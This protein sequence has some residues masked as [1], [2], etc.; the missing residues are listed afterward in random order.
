MRDQA[1][2]TFAV[3]PLF[4]VAPRTSTPLPKALDDDTGAALEDVPVVAIVDVM[5]SG[6]AEEGGRRD[7]GGQRL[8]GTLTGTVLVSGPVGA[9]SIVAVLRLV[10]DSTP[11]GYD[12]ART[13]ES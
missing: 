1:A 5:V 2:N 4:A 11:G 13:A 6:T 3:P 7:E 8:H 9:R 10:S 12:E